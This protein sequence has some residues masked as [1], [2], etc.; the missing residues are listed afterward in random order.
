MASN[1]KPLFFTLSHVWQSSTIAVPWFRV[2]KWSSGRRSA[3]EPRAAAE[4]ASKK[5]ETKK[6]GGTMAKVKSYLGK[7]FDWCFENAMLVGATLCMGVLPLLL[8]CCFGSKKKEPPAAA[9][10]PSSSSGGK[11]KATAA[12]EP[13]PSSASATD[14]D[15]MPEKAVGKKG[16]GKKR[17]PKTE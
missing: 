6:G 3:F 17:T 1:L 5:E 4:K 15:E 12:S 16:G 10:E 2:K 9:A 14:A 11:K 7:A 13:G 8:F